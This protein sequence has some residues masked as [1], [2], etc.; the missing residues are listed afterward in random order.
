MHP[1]KLTGLGLAAVFGILAMIGTTSL[2]LFIF[3]GVMVSVGAGLMY[4]GD[5][6]A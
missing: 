5:R 4:L 1:M 6:M 2:G 3:Y